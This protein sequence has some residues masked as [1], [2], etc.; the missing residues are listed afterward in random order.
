VA[1][2]AESPCDERGVIWSRASNRFDATQVTAWPLWGA[3]TFRLYPKVR[4]LTHQGHY[5]LIRDVL[6]Q[7]FD[8]YFCES[9]G[10]NLLTHGFVRLREHNHSKK[11]M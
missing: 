8:K 3:S 10:G 9:V 2:R 6:N 4:L 5:R 1:H 11:P 7:P